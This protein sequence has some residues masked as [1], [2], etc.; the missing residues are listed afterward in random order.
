MPDIVGA[1]EVAVHAIER[2]RLRCT[3]M[4]ADVLQLIPGEG[5]HAAVGID[6]SL[7]RR[8]AVGRGHRSGEMLEA[9]L[10]P[11]HGAAAGTRGDAHQHD[12]GKHALLDAK[13]A[14][15]IR[16][17]AQAETIAR[18]FERARHHRMQAERPHEVRQHV[19][20]VLGGIVF[21]NQAVGFDRRAGVA[22][23]ADGHRDAPGGVGES[24]L[25]IAVTE[26]AFAR[27][28]GTQTFMQDRLRR[29]ER[30]ERVNNRGQRL[31][32]DL[33]KVERVLG[34]CSG[35]SRRRPPPARQ[36]SGRGQRQSASIRS[37]L[38]RRRP[39]W[40]TGR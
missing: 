24:A 19:V 37:A 17:R 23:I 4:R 13:A 22:R 32:I 9:V 14:A 2:C 28:V 36:H 18:N 31:V 34:E 27:D 30:G 38:S 20:G 15:G 5:A 25:G 39:G 7:Q 8:Y 26:G 11:F 33:D 35:C 6:R 10:D 40:R 12:V 29:V 16:R 1:G 21:G 3:D